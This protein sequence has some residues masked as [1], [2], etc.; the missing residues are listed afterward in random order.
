M[1]RLHAGLGAITACAWAYYFV[2]QKLPITAD[3]GYFAH[4]FW[5]LEHG[6]RSVC[7]LLQHPFTLLL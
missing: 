7:R 4:V 2:V 1:A 3:E 5:L 6:Y